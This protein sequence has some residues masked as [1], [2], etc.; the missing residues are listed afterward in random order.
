MKKYVFYMILAIFLSSCAGHGIP[1][2]VGKHYGASAP[3]GEGI[4]P[5]IDFDISSGTSIIAISNG[6]VS[7]VGS[8][9]GIENGI[10]VQVSHGEHFRSVYAHISKVFIN[11][12]QFVK[13]GQLIGLSG[14]SNNYSKANYQHLHFGICKPFKLCKR[15]CCTNY[16]QTY[17]PNKFWLGGTPQCFDPNMDYSAY[18][19]KDIT[20]P[21]ACGDYGKALIAESK[22]KD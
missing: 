16:S 9:E 1:F 8:P 22:R 20:F 11:S 10:T 7:Y 17:D 21:I 13:R 14:A 6:K 3:Y 2:Y 18:D 19:Q 15:N 5:G 12:N 4:H